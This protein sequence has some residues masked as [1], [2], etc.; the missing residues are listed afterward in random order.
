MANILCDRAGSLRPGLQAVILDEIAKRGQFTWRNSFAAVEDSPVDGTTYT[1]LLNWT[2]IH[3]DIMI[4]WWLPNNERKN[5]GI[6][7]LEPWVSRLPPQRV[8][9]V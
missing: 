2:T 7:F 6:N 1:D 5:M 9:A 3:Y 4:S 8:V